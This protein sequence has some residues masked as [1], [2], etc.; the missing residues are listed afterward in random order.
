[1]V[2]MHRQSRHN[3]VVHIQA[4]L[5]FALMAICFSCDWFSKTKSPVIA[6]VGRSVLTLEDLNKS[7]PAEYRGSISREQ[8]INYVKQWIDTELL[9]QEA[10]RQKIDKEKE[11]QRRLDQMKRDL[12][13]SEIISRNSFGMN[14]QQFTP[15][16]IKNYYD[17]HKESYVRESDIVK[18][19]EI[20]VS[21]LKT[22]WNVRNIIT[23]T[24]FLEL[25]AQF[26][27]VPVQDSAAAPYVAVKSLPPEIAEVV[28]ATRLNGISLPIK[29]ADGVHIIRVLDKQKAGD[30]CFLEEV[31][32]EIVSALSSESQKK[33]IENLLAS[34]RQKTDLKFYFEQIAPDAEIQNADSSQTTPAVKSGGEQ[35]DH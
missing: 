15:D 8:R 22:G 13:S 34:L 26:S 10:S 6:Q 7:I 29:L 19:M 4:F 18:Y 5:F 31:Q 17:Q 23:L 25:A 14:N 11:I 27:I 20:V 35:T 16:A 30:I 9:V 21:D 1:M 32:D 3:G 33:D 2:S 24:N 12:L 28:L